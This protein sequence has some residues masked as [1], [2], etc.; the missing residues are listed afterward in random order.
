MLCSVLSCV[1]L[2][3]RVLRLLRV[4]DESCVCMCIYVTCSH[5]HLIV[6]VLYTINEYKYMYIIFIENNLITALCT[7]LNTENSLKFHLI[8]DCM[9]LK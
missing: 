6:F 9:I 1:Y 2:Y 7:A 3:T 5:L 4:K 8:Q